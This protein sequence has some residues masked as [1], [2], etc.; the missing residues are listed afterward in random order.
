MPGRYVDLARDGI[1]SLVPYKPGKPMAEVAREFGLTDIVKLASNENPLGPPAAAVEAIR[2]A[3]TESLS[4]YPEPVAWALR[5]RLS[6]LHNVDPACITLGNGS[7]DI[8]VLLAQAYLGPGDEAVYSQYCFLVYPLAVQM[9]GAV[10]RVAPATATLGHDADAI[11]D[12]LNPRTR[13]VFI[14]NPNNP[15]GTWL[16]GDELRRM[17]DAVPKTAIAVVDE[18]Y[19]EFARERDY[20]SALDWF[21]EYENL[22]VTRTF[23]KVYGLAGLRIGYAIS[24]PEIADIINRVRLPFNVNVLAQVGATAALDEREF[25]SR[26]VSVNSE[27][28][29]TLRHGLAD[30]G[31]ACPES[32]GNFVL[33]DMGRDAKSVYE[34][35]LRRGVIVRPVANYGLPNHLRISVGLPEENARCLSALKEVLVP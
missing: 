29:E 18:A 1:R 26:S 6:L 25:V 11:V 16:R 15:T 10:A 8:L 5:Q 17:L 31:I 23:S 20:T 19:F 13:I 33:A 24:N 28:L 27:G 14:A 2:N 22:V 9:T 34:S 12:R 32:A 7:N 35:L 3:D 4:R 30:L 21:R